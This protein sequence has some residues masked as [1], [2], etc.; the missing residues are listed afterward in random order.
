MGTEI[1]GYFESD[2]QMDTTTYEGYA[3]VT[4]RSW[5]GGKADYEIYS[6]AGIGHGI[7]GTEC[8]DD[9]WEFMN[10]HP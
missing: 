6:L 7:N 10:N 1:G 3:D 9:M 5:R 8:L 2:M 4:I